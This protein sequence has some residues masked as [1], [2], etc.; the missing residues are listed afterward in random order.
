[1]PRVPRRLASV[2]RA[3]VGAL[4][5]ASAGVAN[6]APEPPEGPT[7]AAPSSS[8]GADAL[9]EARALFESAVQAQEA[10]RF[11]EALERYERARKTVTTPTLLFN[12]AA[13]HEHLG[14]LLRAEALYEAALAEA[15][16]KSADVIAHEAR[17]RLGTL[18]DEIP[19]VTVRL[20]RGTVGAEA[21]LDAAPVDATRL[22]DLRVDPGSH[23]L[24]VRSGRHDRAFGLSFEIA[25]RGVRVI[26]VDLGPERV[27]PAPRVVVRK[28]YVPAAVAAGGTVALGV[29][30]LVT[31]LAGL[32]AEE[33]Y[34]ALNAAPKAETRAE[35]EELRSE[36]R[37]LYT[38]N[39]VLTG[40]AVLALAATTYFFLRPPTRVVEPTRAGLALH[41]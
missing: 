31:G 6:A 36:A 22:G 19:R 27:A 24:H 4:V 3:L 29:A 37:S 15:E 33:R 8:A 5:V 11:R 26:D 17:A 35:R 21:T 2:S 25:R 38:A 1:M 34:D 39:T 40:A 18:R 30:A 14:E 20:A 28:N 12:I 23:A 32:Q 7:P 10:G 41:F 13:C 16:A 9:A